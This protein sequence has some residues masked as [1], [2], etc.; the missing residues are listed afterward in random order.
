VTSKNTSARIIH[1]FKTHTS[2]RTHDMNHLEN[3]KKLM[4]TT[5]TKKRPRAL[6]N[7]ARALAKSVHVHLQIAQQ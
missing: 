1:N 4:S 7:S 6:A 3:D 5:I 2:T